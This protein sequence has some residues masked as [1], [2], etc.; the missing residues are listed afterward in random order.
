MTSG[1]GVIM[2]LYF[3]N[4]NSLFYLSLDQGTQS[5]AVDNAQEA[6]WHT[7]IPGHVFAYSAFIDTRHEKPFIA[8]GAEAYIYA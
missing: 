8:I 7:V 3:I 4:Y 1:I 6:A 2:P 5:H